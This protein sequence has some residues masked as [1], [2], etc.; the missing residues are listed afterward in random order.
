MKT[1][2]VLK[3]ARIALGLTEHEAA[4]KIGINFPSYF[5]LESDEDELSMLYSLEEVFGICKVLNI[6]LDA[7]FEKPG[8]ADLCTFNLVREK[9]LE[10]SKG[11]NA[12]DIEKLE[13][14]IGWEITPILNDGYGLVTYSP[15]AVN[16]ICH[17]I[18]FDRH[19]VIWDL[20]E[21]WVERNN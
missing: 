3:N 13:N 8:N 9:L 17:A 6:P 16:D 15:D 4:A 14:T 1:D 7:L 5:D 2:E 10:Q 19:A 11:M 18:G 21:T 20:Y 12:E